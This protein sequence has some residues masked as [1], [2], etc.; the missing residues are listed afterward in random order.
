MLWDL[1]Y[2]QYDMAAILMTSYL[3]MLKGRHSLPVIFVFSTLFPYRNHQ[4]I[5][6]ILQLWVP[7]DFHPTTMFLAPD[8]LRLDYAGAV[9]YADAVLI[10]VNS[11]H[12]R[13]VLICMECFSVK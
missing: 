8:P 5:S 9:W 1:E 7:M 4:N 13:A 3:K 11:A 2:L 12:V 6:Y 10:V